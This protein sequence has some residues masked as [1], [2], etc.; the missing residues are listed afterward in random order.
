MTLNAGEFSLTGTPGGTEGTPYLC[1]RRTALDTILVEAAA[2]AGAEIRQGFTVTG[3][4]EDD[5]AVAGVRGHSRDNGRD[6]VTERA[7][8]VI[9]ADG[10][11][12]RVAE[13]VGARQYNELPSQSCYY[14]SYFSGTR[15]IRAAELCPRDGVAVGGCPTNDDTVIGIV[16]VQPE[17]ARQFGSDSEAAF[18]AAFDQAPDFTERLRAGTREERFHTTCDIP[19]FYRVPHG[20]GWALVGDAGYHK[21]PIM[22]QGINDAYRDA[23][24]LSAAVHD[25]LTGA[26]DMQE[27]LADYHHHRD[28]TVGPIYELNGQFAALE[29]PPADMVALL[30]ALQGNQEQVD[31]F[32][33]V[34]AN[35]VPVPDFFAPDN[36]ESIMTNA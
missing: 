21:D 31:R 13:A 11:H 3:L 2:E 23:E 34:F 33:G 24:E 10:I 1:C 5:G 27:A 17:I 18:W 22:A 16:A 15:D 32:L 12:S 8:I 35:T 25:G 19:G 9:G 28:A 26:R 30:V 14:Y 7:R 29:P 4:V 6:E 20:P 36:L